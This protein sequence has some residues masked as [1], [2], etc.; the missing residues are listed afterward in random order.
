MRSGVP[1]RDVSTKVFAD[2]RV[3]GRLHDG[4]E[5]SG[6]GFGLSQRGFGNN[7][8]RRLVHD[9]QYAS[10][11]AVVISKRGIG[12]IEIDLFS[13]S[14]P[15]D[16]ERPIMGYQCLSGRSNGVEKRLEVIPQFG[17][18]LDSWTAECPRVLVPD[19]RRISVI[20]KRHILRSPEQ[21]DLGSC[22]QNEIN[23]VS[24]T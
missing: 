23:G 8:L 21:D 12:D 10:D 20:V 14:A 9:A 18:A 22:R 19:G 3:I 4:C 5:L 16:V 13:V 7:A 24:Q 11:A 17:P 15:F 1:A 2:Y 6:V